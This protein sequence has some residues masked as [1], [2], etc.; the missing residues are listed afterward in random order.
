M[1]CRDKKSANVTQ[2]I[3][4]ITVKPDIPD[5][6]TT[7]VNEEFSSNVL[8]IKVFKADT[9]KIKSLFKEP[10]TI[11]IQEK[12]E[13]G[14]KY[15]LYNFATQTNKLILF[16]NPDGGFYIATGVINSNKIILNKG[17]SIGMGKDIFLNLLN[18]SNIKCNTF[19]V[20]DDE[21]TFKTS[22]IFKHQKLSQIKMQQT[23]E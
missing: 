4:Q 21:L 22:F 11:S 9:N 12:E 17:I 7:I 2:N 6:D 8:G 13:Q 20:T 3:A 15:Y 1:G 14:G 5:C 18:L 16:Y 19:Y 10:V 23:M